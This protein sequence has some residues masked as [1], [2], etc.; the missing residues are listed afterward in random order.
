MVGGRISRTT[1]EDDV[2]EGKEIKGGGGD[3]W[4]WR[5]RT[6]WDACKSKSAS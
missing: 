4:G 2:L 5:G 3:R 1:I 6:P